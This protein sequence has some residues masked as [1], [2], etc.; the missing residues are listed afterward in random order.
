VL[1]QPVSFFPAA[2]AQV[3][4]NQPKST[5]P[6]PFK[7]RHTK[8]FQRIGQTTELEIVHFAAKPIGGVSDQITVTAR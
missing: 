8:E 7:A 6:Q 1:T 2:T 4:P 3:N 5:H